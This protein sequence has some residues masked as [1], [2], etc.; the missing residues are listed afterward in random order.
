MMH[1]AGECQGLEFEFVRLTSI[2]PELLVLHCEMSFAGSQ[3]S[4][5]VA[6]SEM[7]H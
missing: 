2:A 1:I 3:V 7:C 5:T 6:V 4:I